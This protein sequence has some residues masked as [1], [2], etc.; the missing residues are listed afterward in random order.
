MLPVLKDF[1]CFCMKVQICIIDIAN[2]MCSL[3]LAGIPTYECL[4]YGIK[5]ATRYTGIKHGLEI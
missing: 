2:Y 3:A 4:H 5:H 1:L